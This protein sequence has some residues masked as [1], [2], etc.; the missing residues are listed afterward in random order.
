MLRIRR[1]ENKNVYK[2]YFFSKIKIYFKRPEQLR[3]ESYYLFRLCEG[4]EVLW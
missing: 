2:A 3:V 1:L 4:S